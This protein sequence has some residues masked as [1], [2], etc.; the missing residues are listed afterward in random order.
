MNTKITYIPVN[1]LLL[2]LLWQQQPIA[3]ITITTRMTITAPATPA[4]ITNVGLCRN[5]S[6]S[7]PV[8]PLLLGPLASIKFNIPSI[9]RT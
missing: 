2:Y 8:D 6:S 4:A 9:I 5:S 7:L 1:F 3:H